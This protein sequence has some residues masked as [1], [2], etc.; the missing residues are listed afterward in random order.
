[1]R[2]LTAT[3][4]IIASMSVCASAQTV[5]EITLARFDCGTGQ[6]P[7]DVAL[8]FTDTYAYSG[9]KIQIVYSC[10]LIKHGDEYMVWD[11]IGRAHV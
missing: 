9:L 7:T 6:A 10:Y 2:N 5:P 4:A 1:M 3:L 8:R 11:E